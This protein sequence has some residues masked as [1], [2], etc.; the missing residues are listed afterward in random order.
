MLHVIASNWQEYPLGG[1]L[2]TQPG[3]VCRDEGYIPPRDLDKTLV[4]N[5]VLY[6][7]VSNP[8]LDRA[9]VTDLEYFLF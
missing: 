3:G 4:V 2:A 1:I 7:E 8:L 6:L 5:D 9:C